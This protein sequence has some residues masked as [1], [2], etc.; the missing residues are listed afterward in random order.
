LFAL[1]RP[2]HRTGKT[3]SPDKAF[4]PPSGNAK[5]ISRMALRYS[6]LHLVR[7]G[8]RV[9][10]IRRLR[11]HPGRLWIADM[12]DGASLLRATSGAR[13]KRVARIRRLRRHP[14]RLRIQIPR[15]ALRYPGYV[16]CEGGRP[17][18]AFTPPSGKVVKADTPDRASLPGYVWCERENGSRIRRLRHH[19]GRL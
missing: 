6:G 9:A 3:G 18:K 1:R 11:R 10:R 4:T 7:E 5:Q 2:S 8:K 15:I 17:D 14:G 19:P 13:G 16:W 12:P